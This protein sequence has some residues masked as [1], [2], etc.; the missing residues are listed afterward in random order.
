MANDC[1]VDTRRRGCIHAPRGS[2]CSNAMPSS[3]ALLANGVAP[4]TRHKYGHDDGVARLGGCPN[5]PWVVFFHFLD[6]FPILREIS[7]N[8]R[9]HRHP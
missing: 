7:G 8:A 5:H 2:L 6:K 4:T 9:K 1:R 3:S